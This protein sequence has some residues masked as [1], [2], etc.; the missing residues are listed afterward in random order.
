MEIKMKSIH[1]D[2]TESLQAF[3]EKKVAKLEKS[4]EDIQKAEVQLKVV[5]PATALNKQASIEVTVPG[6][7]LYVEKTCDTFE[8]SVDQCVDSMRVQLTKFKE[9]MR[10]R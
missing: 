4:Y 3:I 1:F 6:S 9:K 2:A 10:S 8:E 7:K 5:K